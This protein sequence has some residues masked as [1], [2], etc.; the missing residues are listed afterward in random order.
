MWVLLVLVLGT[1][2][3]TRSDDGTARPVT[4]MVGTPAMQ[5]F[6]SETTCRQAGE[7]MDRL[8][9]FSGWGN[10]TRF[11]QVRWTCVPK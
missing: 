1:T 6:G 2:E 3:A 8:R 7:S 11:I 5:E 10:E 4:G 9:G